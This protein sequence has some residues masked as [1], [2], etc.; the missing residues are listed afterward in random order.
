MGSNIARFMPSIVTAALVLGAAACA[1]AHDELTD[2]GQPTPKHD[3]PTP[4]QG[5]DGPEESAAAS[6]EEELSLEQS[7]FDKAGRSWDCCVWKI[8]NYTDYCRSFW[9][10]PLLNLQSCNSGG[11]TLRDSGCGAYRSCDGRTLT[12]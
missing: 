7:S 6:D 9:G 3:E 11:G 1:P 4:G 8:G 10:M 12:Y 5:T 2:E